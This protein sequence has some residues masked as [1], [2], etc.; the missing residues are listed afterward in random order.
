[1]ADLNVVAVL[2]AK[3]GH[4]DQVL[5]ALAALVEPTRAEPGCLSYQ[6]FESQADTNTFITVELWRSQADLDQHLASPHLKVAT[7]AAGEALA[8]SPAIH[9]LTPAGP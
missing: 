4:R 5:A 8:A 2:T 9:P 3:E 7:D 6:L 1:M